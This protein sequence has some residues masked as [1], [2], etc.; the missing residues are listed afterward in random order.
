MS[1]TLTAKRIDRELTNQL[2]Q[3][4]KGTREWLVIFCRQQSIR[5]VRQVLCSEPVAEEIFW[6][7]KEITRLALEPEYISNNH[8]YLLEDFDK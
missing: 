3:T 5:Q 1:L 8:I 4:L 6:C 2:D 7:R